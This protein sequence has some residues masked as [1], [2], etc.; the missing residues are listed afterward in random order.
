MFVR[1]TI[2]VLFKRDSTDDLA[3]IVL[4]LLQLIFQFLVD[5]LLLFDTFFQLLELVLL[6]ETSIWVLTILKEQIRYKHSHRRDQQ[7][8][9]TQR[10]LFRC[11]RNLLFS[12]LLF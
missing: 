3:L 8:V 7:T 9:F 5:L 2:P 12:D 6:A 1:V 10:F 4:S 11:H